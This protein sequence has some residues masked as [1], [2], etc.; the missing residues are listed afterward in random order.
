MGSSLTVGVFVFE[1]AEELDVVG[2]WEVLGFWAAHVA[3]A[4]VRL[5]TVGREEG[6]VRCAKGL[7]LGVDHDLAAAPALD[8][9]IHPGGDGTRVLTKDSAH[10]DWLTQLHDQGVLLASVCTGSLVLAAAG[11][12]K[13][14]SATTHR[15][16]AGKLAA[17]D[18]TI[19]VRA[20]DRYVD[21]GDIVTS[22]GV[23]AGIDMAF[24]LVE[25]LDSAEAA[26]EVRQGTQ[27][28]CPVS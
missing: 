7:R 26:A 4:P 20:T 27:Y 2:P 13:G 14:R 25:R 23:S 15:D 18:D 17:I 10:L 16:F 6:W 1:D 22:A 19:D 12:L 9:L 24:H 8:V 21:D 3:T 5:V 11:L 28:D